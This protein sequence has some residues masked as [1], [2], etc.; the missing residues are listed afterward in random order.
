MSTHGNS[1]KKKIQKNESKI[2]GKKTSSKKKDSKQG[3]KNRLN[4]DTAIHNDLVS[5]TSIPFKKKNEKLKS[6]LKSSSRH[7]K[8]SSSS[9]IKKKS[10]T[11]PSD[12]RNKPS[13]PSDKIG[14][15]KVNW[16]N[17]MAT[18]TGEFLKKLG[19]N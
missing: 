2:S 19:K 5:M 17:S 1:I 6:V 3:E 7:G 14:D 12:P 8:H 18:P 15:S 16:K 10:S 4:L 9:S 11:K 13:A